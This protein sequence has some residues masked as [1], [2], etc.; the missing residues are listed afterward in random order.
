[1]RLSP[2]RSGR[3]VVAW[4]PREE[5]LDS[6]PRD[7]PSLMPALDGVVLREAAVL[8]RTAR[9]IAGFVTRSL[10]SSGCDPIGWRPGWSRAFGLAWR[11]V[12]AVVSREP[13][14]EAFSRARPFPRFQ[15]RLSGRYAL[16]PVLSGVAEDARTARGAGWTSAVDADEP[17]RSA[18]PV[19]RPLGDGGPHAPRA[20]SA[21]GC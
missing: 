15:P 5:S 3:L 18:S 8:V 4:R 11:P 7:D 13:A 9:T 16:G 10:I 14:K 20:D 19:A 17:M 2:T 21:S 1:M 12:P 6:V